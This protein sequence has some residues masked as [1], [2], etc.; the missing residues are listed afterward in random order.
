MKKHEL[1]RAFGYYGG[2]AKMVDRIVSC[3]PVE[4]TSWHELFVG[5]GSI[6]FSKE[7]PACCQHEV[8]NDY[9]GTIANFYQ[10]LSDEQKG[11][12]LMEE[13]IRRGMNKFIFMRAKE[14]IVYHF[15]KMNDMELAVSTYI[16]IAQSFSAMR[17]NYADGRSETAYINSIKKHLPKIRARLLSGI[18]VKNE[19]AIDLLESTMNDKGAIVYLDPPYREELRN[20]EGY[21]CESDIFQQVR[22]LRVLQKCKCNVLL[23][24]YREE[25]DIDLYDSYLIPYGFKVYKLCEATKSCQSK[26][27]KDKAVE[28]IWC[29]YELPDGAL[30]EEEV[31]SKY[32]YI[33]YDEFSDDSIH[34]KV[35]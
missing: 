17:R 1:V 5:A 7:K 26:R 29:N 31:I 8:I 16:E 3:L 30:V 21:R 25:Y 2:K 32:K 6:T 14:Y 4:Y 23:S 10:V 12:H 34:K 35:S 15:N 13:L 24:G 22:L 19:D 28:Y 27:N 33:K 18:T 20:G 9:D 11:K